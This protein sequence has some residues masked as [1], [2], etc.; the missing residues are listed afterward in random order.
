MR[1]DNVKGEVVTL[2][3][4]VHGKHNSGAVAYIKPRGGVYYID[5]FRHRGIGIEGIEFS[6]YRGSVERCKAVAREW[7]GKGWRWQVKEG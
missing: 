7:F 1:C 6:D 2:D 3:Y 5:L 4:T